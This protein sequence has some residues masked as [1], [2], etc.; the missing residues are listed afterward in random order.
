MSTDRI[1]EIR[2]RA[3]AATPG[4][5]EAKRNARRGNTTVILDPDGQFVAHYVN[6]TDAEFLA[7]ARQ[8]IPHL[9]DLIDRVRAAVAEHR[10][11]QG[12]AA[13]VPVWAIEEAIDGG[14]G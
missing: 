14:E 6:P 12:P 7:A 8:D 3:D 11:S 2:A 5:W 9:L 1:A 13:T 4:P 10:T